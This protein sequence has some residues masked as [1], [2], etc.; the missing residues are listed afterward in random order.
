MSETESPYPARAVAWYA[1]IVLAIL[2]WVSVL[3]RFII[4]LLVGP[5]KRDLGLTDVQFG[6]LQGFGFSLT[7]GVIG[8][9]CGV[10]ADRYNRR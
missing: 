5:M 3:D 10:L 1:T 9:A 6:M 7:Y 4:S 2:Y 8:L